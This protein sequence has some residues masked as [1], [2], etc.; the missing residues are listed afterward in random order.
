[1]SEI[2]AIG[3]P[4]QITPLAL[5]GA[6][7]YAADTAEQARAAWAALPSTV[8][9]VVLTEPAAEALA[10]HRGTAG[11]PLTVVMAPWPA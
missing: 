5:A 2:A 9:M 4:G 8:G 10:A 3:A 11:S 7:I 6:R 1:M